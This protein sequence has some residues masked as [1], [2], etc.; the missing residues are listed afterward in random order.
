[1]GYH[2]I[3]SNILIELP[4]VEVI[5]SYPGIQ[6]CLVQRIL[7]STMESCT[8]DSHLEAKELTSYWPISLLPIVSKVFEELL[9]AV[10]NNGQ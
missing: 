3:T 7:P 10:E 2:L 1:L 4:T 8:A 5:I 6:C 9:P